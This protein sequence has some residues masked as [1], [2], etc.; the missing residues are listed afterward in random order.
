VWETTCNCRRAKIDENQASPSKPEARDVKSKTHF[1]L[2]CLTFLIVPLVVRPGE[3]KAG[4]ATGHYNLSS[5]SS[6]EWLKGEG[7]IDTLRITTMLHNRGSTTVDIWGTVVWSG[8]YAPSAATQQAVQAQAESVAKADYLRVV[9]IGELH[10]RCGGRRL[11]F[12]TMIPYWLHGMSLNCRTITIAPG[13]STQMLTHVLTIDRRPFNASPGVLDLRAE[14]WTN[15][16][17]RLS[18]KP[19]QLI[20]SLDSLMVPVP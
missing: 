17:F 5:T 11:P 2:L 12:F 10:V 14:M 13:E 19:R 6:F 15:R 18:E 7:R 9:Q 16:R 20:A 8:G 1:M 3:A 4:T